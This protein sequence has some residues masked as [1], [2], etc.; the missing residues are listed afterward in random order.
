MLRAL[1]RLVPAE[2]L[3]GVVNVGDDLTLHGLRI[4]PDLDTITYT[5][6]GLDNTETGWGLTGET[7]RVM[8]ELRALGGEAWFGLGDRDLATHLYRTQRLIQGDRLSEITASLLLHHGVATTLLPATEDPLATTFETANHETLSFQEYFVR[9]HHAIAIRAVRIEGA[10]D[11]TPG[12]GVLEALATAER[13]I[14]SPSN[15]IISIAPILAVPEIREAVVNRRSDTVAVSPLVGGR[16]LKGP[17]DRLLEEVGHGATAEGIARTYREIASTLV[18]DQ[19]DAEWAPAVEAAG[20]ACVVTGTV[21]DTPERSLRLA[22][23]VL[24][25]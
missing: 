17:A 18:I 8:E 12:P 16:A 10:H 24:G 15:P 3:V 7:W 9:H 14:I 23:V 19:V 11:A 6:A 1:S 5:L 2:E 25:V 13:I 22:E 21:M 4:C 20:M